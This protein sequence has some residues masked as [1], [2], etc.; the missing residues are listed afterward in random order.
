MGPTDRRPVTRD[1]L[2]CGYCVAKGL[3]TTALLLLVDLYG[4]NLDDPVSVWWDGFVRYD[5]QQISIRDVLAHK[6]GLH[7]MFPSDLT[8]S[9]LAN[10]QWMIQMIEDAP[11]CSCVGRLGR[12]AYLIYG[13]VVSEIIQCVS[14]QTVTDFVYNQLLAPLGL[15]YDI[16]FPIPHESF[17]SSDS[18]PS[19]PRPGRLP[20]YSA[21][22]GSSASSPI[23][24]AGE[25]STVV[26]DSSY[27]KV[28]QSDLRLDG[29]G[30]VPSNK[31]GRIVSYW[32]RNV[33]R[34]WNKRP[35]PSD[36]NTDSPQDGH[37]ASQL[38]Q[39]EMKTGSSSIPN[40][41]TSS[42][43]NTLASTHNTLGSDNMIAKDHSSDSMTGTGWNNDNASCCTSN[44]DD[45]GSLDNS[46]DIKNQNELG[47]N[48]DDHGSSSTTSRET[49][50]IQ[51]DIMKSTQSGDLAANPAVYSNSTTSSS[52]NCTTDSSNSANNALIY[53]TST[54]PSLSPPHTTIGTPP[55][56]VASSNESPSSALRCAA[57][58]SLYVGILEEPS[59]PSSPLP[60][61]LG[62]VEQSPPTDDTTLTLRH[63]ISPASFSSSASPVLPPPATPLPPASSLLLSPS[64][65][66]LPPSPTSQPASAP[67]AL[68]SVDRH[69]FSN[70]LNKEFLGTEEDGRTS[71]S[72]FAV[73][74]PSSSSTP[75][76]FSRPST[77]MSSASSPSSP[78]VSSP[79]AP[80]SPSASASESSCPGDGEG[81]YE[82]GACFPKAVHRVN[83]STP[84]RWR[85]TSARRQL[86]FTTISNQEV[87]EK[88]Q[89]AKRFAENQY[90]N[91]KMS[92]KKS[93]GLEPSAKPRVSG[94]DLLRTKPHVMDPLIYDSKR[95]LHLIV[96]P[97]NIRLTARGLALFYNALATNKILN[98]T[99][100]KEATSSPTTYDDSL[101]TVFVTGGS[102]RIWGLGYQLFPC[103]DMRTGKTVIGFGHGD[104]GGSVGICFP[105]IGVS[106]GMLFNDV[107]SGPQASRTVLE[108][109][110]PK[111][112]LRPNWK[113]PVDVEELIRGIGGKG[114]A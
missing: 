55:F 58:T 98:S 83:S 86:E 40:N 113:S 20:P 95:L 12:Y 32:T 66:S 31:I 89:K 38:P 29:A 80:L 30:E 81:Y 41:T 27:Q 24:I 6:A 39:V 59:P 88:I 2:F 76:A 68:L 110:L 11:V 16:Y 101:E 79:T 87:L 9:R 61:R 17:L 75:M 60:P 96:P 67:S 53:Y 34:L 5:K 105:T 56:S 114:E 47:D 94:V 65:S 90:P 63:P 111:F 22:S 52:S 45:A 69:P 112:G 18:P 73:P 72:E 48:S 49:V 4:L 77:L 92:K 100:I 106:V 104:F 70:H 82:Q 3:L 8:L 46:T 97:A 7:R 51:D 99:T 42:H 93:T 64:T 33:A 54:P 71:L 74:R 1:A 13:W 14:G 84:L 43:S 109:L 10:Y 50:C 23:R 85:L 107:I 44:S 35:P 57:S 21:P 62:L 15:E 19:P 91:N 25:V 78:A 26:P 28:L 102:S 103:L 37:V 36:P 108:F